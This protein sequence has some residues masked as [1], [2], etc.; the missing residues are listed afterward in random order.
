MNDWC[1]FIHWCVW[2]E[3][4]VCVTLTHHVLHSL[5]IC[6]EYKAL[7][8]VSY[9]QHMSVSHVQHMSVPYVQQCV[10]CAA[11]KALIQKLFRHT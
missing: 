4:L 3:C 2:H 1:V 8:S 9:V 10:I 5:I 7:M 6:A 11:Y